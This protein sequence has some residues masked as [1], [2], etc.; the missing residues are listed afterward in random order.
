MITKNITID[1]I[2]IDHPGIIH[3]REVIVISEDGVEISR[4]FS[5]K[6]YTPD[7]PAESL[8]SAIA[9]IANVAWTYEVVAE[10]KALEAANR[11]R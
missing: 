3:A 5:R 9:A 8:P 11:K 2:Q 10:F 6:T 4:A 1:R 7:T